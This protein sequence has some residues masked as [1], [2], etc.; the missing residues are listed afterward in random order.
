MC[1]NRTYGP[2]AF[3]DFAALAAAADTGHAAGDEA[4]AGAVFDLGRRAKIHV[5][6]DRAEAAREAGYAV[7]TLAVVRADD[8]PPN[9]ADVIVGVPESQ[10]RALDGLR[11]PPPPP[12]SSS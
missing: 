11:S 4:T 6:L 10:S 3:G 2:S 7:A 12:P 1:V 5:E 9:K 8:A